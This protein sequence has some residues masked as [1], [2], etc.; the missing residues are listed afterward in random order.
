MTH[1]LFKTNEKYLLITN[2]I[3]VGGV[4]VSMLASSVVDHGFELGRV[5][6]E[7]IKLVFA[8]SPLVRSKI[9]GSES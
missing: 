7:A 6:S 3:R 5:K 8:A 2:G 4:T 1:R 9:G